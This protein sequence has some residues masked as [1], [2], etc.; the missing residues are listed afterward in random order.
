[1]ELDIDF[2]KHHWSPAN[3]VHC[4]L[5]VI[6]VQTDLFHMQSSLKLMTEYHRIK[7]HEGIFFNYE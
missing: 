7:K 2:K 3:E 1:M 6:R 4:I 5:Y